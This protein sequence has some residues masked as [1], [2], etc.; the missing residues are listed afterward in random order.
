MPPIT[1]GPGQVGRSY[2]GGAGDHL[3]ARLACGAATHAL[4][5]VA[6]IGEAVSC[7]EAEVGR[8]RV[9]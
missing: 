2:C 8:L 4:Y 9:L 5:I 6:N 7:A 3:L 1:S